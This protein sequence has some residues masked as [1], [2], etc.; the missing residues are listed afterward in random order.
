MI[1]SVK[2]EDPSESV[3]TKQAKTDFKA[4]TFV[5]VATAVTLP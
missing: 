4:G 5:V 3:I 2:S 1:E